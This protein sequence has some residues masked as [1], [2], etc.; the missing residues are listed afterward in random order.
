LYTVRDA[1]AADVEGTLAAIRAMGLDYIEL[2]GTYGRPATEFAG[3]LN[4]HG[5][6]VSGSH[7][8]IDALEGNFGAVVEESRIFGNEWIIVPYIG[9]ER[10]NWEELARTFSAFADRLRAEGLRF[11]YHNHDFEF[12]P[13][14][15]MRQ[16]LAHS[17][18]SVSFQVDLGWVRYAGDDPAK[19][20][21]EAGSRASLVHLKD[22]APDRENPHV[23]AGDGQVDWTSVLMACDEVGVQFGA[24]E[25]DHPPH[26]PITDT[27]TCVKYFQARGLS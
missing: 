20:M 1:M 13:D 5:L 4:R 3:V 24:I 22:L 7:V 9:Q 19:F 18:P 14:Q 26:D 17:S 25:M 8:G 2:A 6:R 16:L 27:G 10:R 23:V 11:A 12:G 21:R 15:G